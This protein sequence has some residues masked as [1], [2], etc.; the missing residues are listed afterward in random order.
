[1]F[2]TIFRGSHEQYFVQLL[3]WI[4]LMSVRCVF[5]AVCGRTCVITVCNVTVLLEW[6]NLQNILNIIK[7]ERSAYKHDR[8]YQF[9]CVSGAPVRVRSGQ[10]TFCTF[11]THYKGARCWWSSWLRHC[12]TSRK[13]AGSIPDSVIR[14]FNWHNPSGRTMVLGSTLPLTEMSTRNIS[15]GVKVAGA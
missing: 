9:L 5:Y 10:R 3:S 6:L 8:I 2:T 1:M 12:A 11:R 4:P 13:V 15:W 7:M 14:Y